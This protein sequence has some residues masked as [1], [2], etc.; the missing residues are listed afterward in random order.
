MKTF[1]DYLSTMSSLGPFQE[2]KGYDA[3]TKFR[4]Q[5]FEALEQAGLVKNE[6]EFMALEIKAI[7]PYYSILMA[8]PVQ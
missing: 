6:E 5:T 4:A 7:V 3:L 1:F 8:N 2:A